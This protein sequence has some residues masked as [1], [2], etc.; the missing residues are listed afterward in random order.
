MKCLSACITVLPASR[1]AI[2]SPAVERRA[3]RRASRRA[4]AAARSSSRSAAASGCASAQAAR[5]SSQAARAAAPRS[6]DA[7]HVLAHGVGHDERRVRVEA[8]HLLRRAAPRPRRA[9]R[10]APSPCRSRW[11]PG[12]RCASAGRSATA[13]PSS[14]RAAANAA[15]SASRS[16][17]SSTCW[18]CQP[19]A[20]NRLPLSSRDE[21]DR[22]RA[23]DRDVVVVVDVDE[24]AEPELAGDRRG[25]LRDALHQVA[26]GA[27]RVDPRVDDRV[28]RPVPAVGEEALRDREPDAVREA[29]PERPRRR[30]DAR[31]CG[32]APGARA[33]ASP[34]GGTASG[35]RAS[36]R[37][38]RGG[39]R[40]TGGCRRGPAE[41]TKR[42]RP[43]QSGAAGSWRIS[44]A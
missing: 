35:R 9:A 29:L 17:G 14:A 6:R 10:R 37:S 16:F 3:A 22:R 43:G 2:C 34:T 18:T 13:A 11:A 32:R 20:S 36:G 42:S 23:V 24:A 7:G 33:S 25:L 1:V 19:Y 30:L 5:R 21:A 38:R 41:R 26:V 4:G 31:A 8:E 40:R 27:D 12:R 39:A 28:A 15:R 44:S